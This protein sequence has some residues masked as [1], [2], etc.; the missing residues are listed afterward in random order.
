MVKPSY[1]LPLLF[2]YS[3]IDS[4][5]M[6]FAPPYPDNFLKFQVFHGV[7]IAIYLTATILL[8]SFGL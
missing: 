6:Q 4:Q 8:F 2:Q 7:L 3:F 1:I 5:V